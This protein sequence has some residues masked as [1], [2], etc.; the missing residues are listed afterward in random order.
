M[1]VK[2]LIEKLKQFNPDLPVYRHED[3]E[4]C[5]YDTPIEQ[6]KLKN[7]GARYG[8][9]GDNFLPKIRRVTLT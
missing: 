3:V 7:D 6:V 2:E 5:S 9:V 1:T 4:Y 8:H